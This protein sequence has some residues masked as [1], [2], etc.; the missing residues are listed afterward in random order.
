[1][2]MSEIVYPPSE[3]AVVEGQPVLHLS[4][5]RKGVMVGRVFGEGSLYRHS[6]ASF[7]I[8]A[9][10]YTDVSQIARETLLQVLQRHPTQL[11]RFC[12]KS[13]QVIFRSAR[14]AASQPTCHLSLC[15]HCLGS[16]STTC[17]NNSKW[18]LKRAGS[19]CR[20]EVLAY[21]EAV[22]RL[23]SQAK[24]QT[25]ECIE[26]L[27]APELALKPSR[28]VQ[29]YMKKLS[30]FLM[31]DDQQRMTYHAAARVIQ[32]SWRRYLRSKQ[33]SALFMVMEELQQAQ[34]FFA[35]DLAADV[36]A[37][38]TMVTLLTKSMTSRSRRHGELSR[39][40]ILEVARSTPGTGMERPQRT[41]VHGGRPVRPSECRA[42]GARASI[43]RSGAAVSWPDGVDHA[44]PPR[45]SGL[46]MVTVDAHVRHQQSEAKGASTSTSCGP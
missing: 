19:A 17:S 8:R 46:S 32:R 4:V 2:T 44:A 34:R 45:Q 18:W 27:P 5:I 1:M 31:P 43:F 36:A 24:W 3:L 14:S 7:S 21:A 41:A 30:L 11:R 39:A 16:A 20:E 38:E 25:L 29:H 40:S 15:T 28:R 37:T 26:D 10:T 33:A 13:I 35:G 22:H 9:L 23:R 6:E 42:H 12:I